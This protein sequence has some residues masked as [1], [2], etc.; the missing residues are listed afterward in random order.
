MEEVRYDAV[1]VFRFDEGWSSSWTADE[2]LRRLGLEKAG[3][4]KAVLITHATM[5]SA[6]R[7]IQ[8]RRYAGTTICRYADNMKE[9]IWRY[10]WK[11]ILVI[12]ATP[13][14]DRCMRD[15]Q[16]ICGGEVSVYEDDNL[17]MS[18]PYHHWFINKGF[19]VEERP[20]RKAMQWWAREAL[21]SLIPWPIYRWWMSSSKDW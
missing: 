17:R 20:I 11:N 3:E 6:T 19:R 9:C 4:H 7:D 2:E 5:P 13:M 15:M 10:R 12:A 1:V 14:V 18:R 8:N 21:I 16:R